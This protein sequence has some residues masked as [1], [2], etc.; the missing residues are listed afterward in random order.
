MLK[1]GTVL[2]YKL[3]HSCSLISVVRSVTNWEDD[4]AV[5]TLSARLLPVL[6]VHMPVQEVGIKSC[7]VRL[8]DSN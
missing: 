3:R 2:V 7:I 4:S 1:F 8:S 5:H 6:G